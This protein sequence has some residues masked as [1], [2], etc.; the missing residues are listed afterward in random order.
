LAIL[1]HASRTT[2]ARKFVLLGRICQ[3]ILVEENRLIPAVREMQFDDLETFIH[4]KC[5]PVSA[6]IAVEGGTRRILGFRVSQM[7]AKGKLAAKALKKYGPRADHRPKAR[8]ELFPELAPLLAPGCVI[9][10]DM[11]PHYGP[12]VKRHFPDCRH[13]VFK[14]RRACIVGQ[15]ELKVGGRDPLFS[16][17]H[18]YAMLRANVSRL[19]RRSWNTSKRMDRLEAHISIYAVFHNHYV[20]HNPSR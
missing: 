2:I 7:P 15:G 17:N 3:E 13:E 6:G 16:L 20:I 10:T 14:G 1:L 12:A 11:N 9:K 5:K 18:T 8:E 19:F 4:T